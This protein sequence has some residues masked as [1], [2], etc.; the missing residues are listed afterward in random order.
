M[1]CPWWH[2]AVFVDDVVHHKDHADASSYLDCSMF[3]SVTNGIHQN[4]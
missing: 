4:C 1:I 3:E 2:A